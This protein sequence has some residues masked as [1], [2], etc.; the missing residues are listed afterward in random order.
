MKGRVS[1][2]EVV[3]RMLKA[4]G[5]VSNFELNNVCLRYAA[6]IHELRKAGHRITSERAGR[7][8]WTFCYGGFQA[9]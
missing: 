4:H 3:L 1:Q 5:T 9:H 7:G 6:R 2:R 8:E